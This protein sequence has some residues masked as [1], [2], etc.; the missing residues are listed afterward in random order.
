MSG[1]SR[2]TGGPA[3]AGPSFL[4]GASHDTRNRGGFRP[5][6]FVLP[7]AAHAQSW[8]SQPH[9]E[10]CPSKWGAGDTRGSANHMKPESVLK[11]DAADQDG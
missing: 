8:K 7:A 2:T 9:A 6:A 1:F 5:W 11:A 4:P 10:R 3:Q